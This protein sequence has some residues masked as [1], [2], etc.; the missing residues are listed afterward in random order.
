VC[1]GQWGYF[2]NVAGQTPRGLL[3]MPVCG[4]H[5]QR[6]ARKSANGM[7]KISK[8][9]MEV[10]TTLQALG[11]EGG[12]LRRWCWTK[13]GSPQAVVSPESARLRKAKKTLAAPV[14]C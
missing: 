12:V 6:I 3:L 10:V 14:T 8:E 11:V 5:S 1:V 9:R 13:K 2:I 7:E 4:L